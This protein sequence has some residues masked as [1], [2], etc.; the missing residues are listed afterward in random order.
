MAVQGQ[1]AHFNPNILA[2]AACKLHIIRKRILKAYL[3]LNISSLSCDI[4]VSTADPKD[5]IILLQS[6]QCFICSS[7]T[8]RIWNGSYTLHL[9]SFCRYTYKIR[10]DIHSGTYLPEFGGNN[11]LGV[12]YG[13]V[14]HSSCKAVLILI[15]NIQLCFLGKILRLAIYINRCIYFIYF[16]N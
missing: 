16:I 3:F 6:V 14:R 8:Y 7:D 15:N 9:I 2:G 1:N 10:T 5:I 12:I 13:D 4:N 11:N